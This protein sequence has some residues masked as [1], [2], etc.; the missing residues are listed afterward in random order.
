MTLNCIQ[1]LISKSKG[2][3]QPFILTAIKSLLQEGHLTQTAQLVKNKC[4]T[5]NPSTPWNERIPAI[6]NTMRNTIPCGSV[7]ISEDKNHNNF[8]IQFISPTIKK[9]PITSI[10]SAPQSKTKNVQKKEIIKVKNT[11]KEFSGINPK[12]TKLLI[13]GCSD[14]K[15]RQP[16]NL[17][18]QSYQN[19]DFGPQLNLARNSRLNQYLNL[20]H[21]HFNNTN[22]GANDVQKKQY[23]MSALNTANRRPTL[24]VYGSN[25]SPFFCP[26]MKT[27]YL[28]A[29]QNKNL[30]ILIVSGLYGLIRYDDYINDYHFRI[31]NGQNSWGNTI[32]N[33]IGKYVNDNNINNNDVHYCLSGSY[34]PY[35][36]NIHPSWKNRWTDYGTGMASARW[37]ARDL[38]D[39]LQNL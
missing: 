20:P 27:L 3:L 31:D 16:N 21:G 8:T 2:K 37:N 25:S 17:H 18:N 12:T 32:S 38:S 14:S 29:I 15:S 11:N 35:L 19:Y 39:F 4:L 10:N 33:A 6:C 9:S 30:H 23:Y 36:T 1:N 7:I 28:A 5:L 26:N 24:T 13:L 34:L 22:R